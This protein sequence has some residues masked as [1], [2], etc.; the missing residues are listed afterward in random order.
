MRTDQSGM[1][2]E[3]YFLCKPASTSA[4]LE[5]TCNLP[6]RL[7]S[8]LKWWPQH[9]SWNTRVPSPGLP[10]PGCHSRGPKL[11]CVTVQ[12]Y[13]SG[14]VS[15]TCYF[16]IEL[17]ALN[18]VSLL[19]PSSKLGMIIFGWQHWEWKTLKALYHYPQVSKLVKEY[20]TFIDSTR[21]HIILWPTICR[22]FKRE[23]DW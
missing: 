19:S 23:G 13:L 17:L 9:W 1:G 20:Y 3:H 11:C 10:H 21:W 7:F 5:Y 2:G 16:T 12:L 22:H 14:A 8:W 6:W 4:S 18:E 15:Q